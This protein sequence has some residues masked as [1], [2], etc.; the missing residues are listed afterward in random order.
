MGL[1]DRASHRH[2]ATLH[3]VLHFIS[4]LL[5]YQSGASCGGVARSKFFYERF[6]KHTCTCA[7]AVVVVVSHFLHIL[8]ALLI[9]A[10]GSRGNLP[11]TF[12]VLE[13]ISA[14]QLVDDGESWAAIV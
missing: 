10:F 7:T 14:S 6:H 4:C 2:Y 9:M 5:S 12:T 3:F 1:P 11:I 8:I 13:R